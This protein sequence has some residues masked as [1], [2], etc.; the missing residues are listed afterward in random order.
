MCKKIWNFFKFKAEVKSKIIKL[1][2]HAINAKFRYFIFL[3]IHIKLCDLK[4]G[5]FHKSEW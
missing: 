1:F 3:A 5:Y 2:L 4:Y